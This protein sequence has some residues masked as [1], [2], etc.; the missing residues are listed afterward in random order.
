MPSLNPLCWFICNFVNLML[1]D[2]T[3][4]SP[5]T[6]K[7]NHPFLNKAIRCFN[8]AYVFH[9]HEKYLDF[10]Y[11]SLQIA[12]YMFVCG[13][14]HYCILSFSLCIGESMASSLE[15]GSIVSFFIKSMFHVE[16]AE[17]DFS[18]ASSICL[19]KPLT[20][21][22]GLPIMPVGRSTRRVKWV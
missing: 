7:N 13:I 11:L 10:S 20:L 4:I 6:P 3:S 18:T 19:N 5:R 9:N 14:L 1:F 17:Q 12:L 21:K 22:T 2:L 15:F 16:K 8:F